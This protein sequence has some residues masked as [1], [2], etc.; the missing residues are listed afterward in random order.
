MKPISTTLALSA[1]IGGLSL[2]HPVKAVSKKDA[3]KALSAAL[4]GGHVGTSV[5]KTTKEEAPDYDSA[6]S[7]AL[8]GGGMGKA[9]KKT[10]K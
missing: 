5:K 1:L 6:L 3:D 2:I 7:Q 8:Q 4:G 10:S 9:V